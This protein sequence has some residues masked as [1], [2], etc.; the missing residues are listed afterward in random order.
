MSAPTTESKQSTE[1]AM[2]APLTLERQVTHSR[3]DVLEPIDISGSSMDDSA[4]KK[5]F[6]IQACSE[7]NIAFARKGTEEYD[8][9]MR[10][11]KSKCM[12]HE[13]ATL[14]TKSREEIGAMESDERGKYLWRL[15]CTTFGASPR[16]GTQEYDDVMK[17]F[18]ELMKNYEPIHEQGSMEARNGS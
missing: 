4:R 2:G 18:I 3:V 16:S 12:E 10:R 8:R 9:V 7:E 14:P 15:A 13:R 6:W 11:F 1:Y 5:F 17:I